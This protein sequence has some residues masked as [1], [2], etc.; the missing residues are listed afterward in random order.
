MSKINYNN[1]SSMVESEEGQAIH[2]RNS[3]WGGTTKSI[4]RMRDFNLADQKKSG[5]EVE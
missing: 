1:N 5:G 2:S 4:S 3:S